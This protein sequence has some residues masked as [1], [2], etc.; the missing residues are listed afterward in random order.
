MFDGENAYHSSWNMKSMVV[1]DLEQ[2][3]LHIFMVG[4]FICMGF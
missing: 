2:D 3:W 4:R 1:G